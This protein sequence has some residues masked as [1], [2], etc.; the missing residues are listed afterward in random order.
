MIKIKLIP[1]I[2]DNKDRKEFQVKFENKRLLE[3][4][5]DIVLDLEAKEKVNVL[6]II[7]NG[8][9]TEDLKIKPKDEDEIIIVYAISGQ[10]DWIA[11]ITI[12]GAVIGSIIFPAIAPSLYVTAGFAAL[13]WGYNKIA[14]QRKPSYGSA[15]NEI[16]A[17]SPTYGWDGVENTQ[18]AGL[19]LAIIY[20]EN[21]VGGNVINLNMSDGKTTPS[22]TTIF[23]PTVEGTDYSKTDTIVEN[24]RILT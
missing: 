2:I 6:K 20:G 18:S 13:S 12:V 17:S 4:V 21:K 24:T 8:K 23:F 16:D 5:S 9:K 10:D 7:I 14:G 3:I 1:N 22:Y 15:G 11:G 19:P